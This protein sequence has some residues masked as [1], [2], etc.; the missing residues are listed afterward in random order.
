M[1]R[2]VA[3][4]AAVLALSCGSSQANR[5]RAHSV[6]NRLTDASDPLYGLSVEVCD[7]REG[8][9][10]AQCRAEGDACD[11][12]ATLAKRKDTTDACDRIFAAFEALRA[13]QLTARSLA[14]QAADGQIDWQEALTAAQGAAA[15]WSELRITIMGTPW[16][17]EGAKP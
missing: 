15:A 5:D 3:L 2:R 12:P 10:A 1:R 9:I 11:L 13:A 14:D 4:L 7:A 16:L 8:M 6:M 17:Q